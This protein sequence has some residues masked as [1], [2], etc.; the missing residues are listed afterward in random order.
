[1]FRKFFRMCEYDV[2]VRKPYLTIVVADIQQREG[3]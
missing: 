2:I 1:M 3:L